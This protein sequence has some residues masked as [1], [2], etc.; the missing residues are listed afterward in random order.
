MDR[1]EMVQ[2]TEEVQVAMEPEYYALIHAAEEE[3]EWSSFSLTQE[4]WKVLRKR[5]LMYKSASVVEASI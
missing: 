4:H 3:R 2:Q 5:S 1:E